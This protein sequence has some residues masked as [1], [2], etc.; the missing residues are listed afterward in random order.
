MTGRIWHSLQK[1][2]LNGLTEGN[3][4]IG[5]PNKDSYFFIRGFYKDYN[6]KLIPMKGTIMNIKKDLKD[7]GL[8]LITPIPEKYHFEGVD[9][10]RAARNLTVGSLVL[11]VA[12][13]TAFFVGP[14]VVDKVRDLVLWDK[15]KKT[16]KK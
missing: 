5:V 12:F 16:Q 6:E 1:P 3:Q 7:I 13:V 9:N 4:R 10:R 15:F 8:Y 2:K 11:Q 14:T